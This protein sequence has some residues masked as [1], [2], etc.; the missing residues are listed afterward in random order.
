MYS[1]DVLCP[2]YIGTGE[3]KKGQ[4]RNHSWESFL[5]LP[6]IP[7]APQYGTKVS[8]NRAG[9]PPFVS[10]SHPTKYRS[11]VHRTKL[12]GICCVFIQTR[13][14]IEKRVK[15]HPREH[16]ELICWK[17]SLTESYQQGYVTLASAWL[18]A[19]MK[20]TKCFAPI[21]STPCHLKD[22]SFNMLCLDSKTTKENKTT[23]VI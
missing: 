4:V 7:T 21:P 10:T 22:R 12:Q 23:L 5:D 14:F 11:L 8:H 9:H 17:P 2:L 3:E 13:L 15:E 6:R 20:Q 19:Q 16:S 1:N 18:C